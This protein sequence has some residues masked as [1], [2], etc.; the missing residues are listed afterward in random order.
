[1]QP[2]FDFEEW[3]RLARENPEEFESRRTAAI[4]SF[5]AN[6]PAER[7]PRLRGLQFRLDAE[8]RKARTPLGAA[9]RMQAL[10][11]EQVERLRTALN[12]LAS[13]P[14]SGRPR[15]EAGYGKVLPFRPRDD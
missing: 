8:R 12:E 15:T 9:V 10:M 7:V 13:R 6:A 1:M 3:A 14:A 11:R 2:R 4:E 5:I